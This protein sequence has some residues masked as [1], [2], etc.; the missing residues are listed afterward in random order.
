M[1]DEN[2]TLEA[3]L[4]L[5]KKVDGICGSTQNANGKNN[6]VLVQIKEEYDCAIP[7]VVAG[8]AVG[9]NNAVLVQIKREYDS[10]IREVVTRGAS[11]VEK[12]KAPM[13]RSCSH[14]T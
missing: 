3:Q 8:G 10:A 11:T 14:E 9:E 6:A 13:L 12:G 4:A 5:N 2:E 7:D 1:R